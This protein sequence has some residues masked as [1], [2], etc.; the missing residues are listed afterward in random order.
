MS[1]MIMGRNGW[2]NQRRTIKYTTSTKTLNHQFPRLKSPFS[3]TARICVT[4]HH[5][6]VLSNVIT[7]ICFTLFIMYGASSSQLNEHISKWIFYPPQCH[8]KYFMYTV[9]RTS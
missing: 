1:T 4:L 6:T 5:I 9:R 8:N 3:Q 2:Q 7:G